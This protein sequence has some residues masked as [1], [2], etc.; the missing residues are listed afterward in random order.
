MQG[1]RLQN[2]AADSK[3]VLRLPARA[4]TNSG[5]TTGTPR[6]LGWRREGARVGRGAWAALSGGD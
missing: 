4:A 6:E 1:A 3:A 2:L 5:G